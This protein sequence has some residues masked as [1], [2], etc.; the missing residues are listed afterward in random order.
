[1]SLSHP[2][3]IRFDTEVTEHETKQQQQQQQPMPFIAPKVGRVATP[4]KEELKVAAL[5]ATEKIRMK[6]NIGGMLMDTAPTMSVVISAEEHELSYEEKVKELRKKR[7]SQTK[8]S[9]GIIPEEEQQEFDLDDDD[10]TMRVL[11]STQAESQTEYTTLSD[12]GKQPFD[13]K[14]VMEN[15]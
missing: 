13:T 9:V 1:M 15:D 12:V 8:I 5:S 7:A 10:E 3:R 6:Q 2:R 11:H 14:W 4:I